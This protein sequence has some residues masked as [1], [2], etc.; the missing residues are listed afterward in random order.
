[1]SKLNENLPSL[2]RNISRFNH[3]LV[4]TIAQCSAKVHHSWNLEKSAMNSRMR[5]TAKLG[6]AIPGVADTMTGID[7]RR[8]SKTRR[9]VRTEQVDPQ[10]ELAVHPEKLRQA[11]LHQQIL[12][13]RAR[14]LN[15][16]TRSPYSQRP[17][18]GTSRRTVRRTALVAGLA[19]VISLTAGS[20]F[21]QA[22]EA[23]KLAKDSLASTI[24]SLA[25]AGD[26]LSGLVSR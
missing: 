7:R 1:M 17:G 10:A 4:A 6:R 18:S 16:A 26:T 20:L 2:R 21:D 9:P 3:T 11:E 8:T 15:N 14:R 12:A 5:R 22:S 23:R 25:V 24:A 13:N 19:L